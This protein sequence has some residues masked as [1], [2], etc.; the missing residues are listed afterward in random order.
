LLD[1]SAATEIASMGAHL[2]LPGQSPRH[3]RAATARTVAWTV[4]A[5]MGLIVLDSCKQERPLRGVTLG[6]SW[7]HQAQFCGPYYAD[8]HGLYAQEGLRV[9]LVP[10]AAD[11]DPL[12]EFID[13]KYDF[14]IA[15]PDALII[16]RQKGQRIK[17]V[18]A[19]Y[20]VHPLVYL[21]LQ[22]SGI[23]TPQDFRGKTIGVAYSERLPLVAM[24]RK[25]EIDPGETKIVQ[26][27]YGYDGLQKGEYDV[28]AGWRTNELIHARRAGL[29]LNVI[30]PYD[31]G[32]TF[33]ADVLAVRE[34]LIEQEPELVAKL[35]R[36]TM[37][38]WAQALQHPAESA[39]LPLFYNQHLDPAHELE[40][41]K[42]SAP[43]VHTG[44]DQIGWMRAE[45]WE[46]M[47]ATLYDEGMIPERPE[48]EDLYTTR[49]LEAVR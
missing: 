28:E 22:S 44:A 31:Y 43:L 17:A 16:A 21:T 45:D 10:A 30:A 25:L 8:R 29:A 26:R 1:M 6:L 27:T 34:S 4:V 39:K 38:G 49:F 36:A 24:L 5:I 19:T 23:N 32:I 46:V 37:H 2:S 11:R 3:W 33:Y 9:T 12:D 7:V 18:A 40:L 20:R 13:G 14:V 42:A 35:V 48:A 41:L 47:I 15:Q